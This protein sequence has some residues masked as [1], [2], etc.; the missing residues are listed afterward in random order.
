MS[1]RNTT[2]RVRKRQD[3]EQFFACLTAQVRLL[4]TRSFFQKT[5]PI[6]TFIGQ[7]TP[8]PNGSDQILEMLCTPHA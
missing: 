1:F 3:A 5:L 7:W 2:I 8:S 4:L 6:R